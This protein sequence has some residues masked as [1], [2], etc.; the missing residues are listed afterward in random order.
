MPKTV[1]QHMACCDRSCNQMHTLLGSQSEKNACAQFLLTD[2]LR[3]TLTL[4]L[5][6]LA[7]MINTLSS[8]QVCV[9]CMHASAFSTMQGIA[10]EGTPPRDTYS[11]STDPSDDEHAVGEDTYDAARSGSQAISSQRRT[12]GDPAEAVEQAA[13]GHKSP[14]STAQAAERPDSLQLQPSVTLDTEYD[15]GDDPEMQEGQS[16]HSLYACC[17][18]LSCSQTLQLCASQYRGRCIIR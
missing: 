16:T 6:L 18:C 15:P 5:R 11:Q 2:T 7:S 4:Y 17:S 13:D 14:G 10:A 9:H 3:S 12:Q 8:P 1:L